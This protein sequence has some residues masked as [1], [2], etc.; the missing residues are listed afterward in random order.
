MRVVIVGA[1]VSG[2]SL[3]AM[4]RRVN[5]QCLAIEQKPSLEAEFDLPVIPWSNALSCYRAFGIDQMLS[6]PGVTPEMY[7]GIR[8]ASDSRWLTRLT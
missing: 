7:S 5:V 2:L 6:A 8:R 3:A 4:L 1:G